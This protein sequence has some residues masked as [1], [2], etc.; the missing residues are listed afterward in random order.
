MVV[1]RS[2]RSA[3]P[4][5]LTPD[6]PRAARRAFFTQRETA[7][8][9]GIEW[10]LSLREWWLWWQ[11]RNRWEKRGRYGDD[12]VMARRRD[13]GP[14]SLENIY[15]T[16]AKQNVADMSPLREVITPR[17]VFPNVMEAANA[18]K[19]KLLTARDYA[20]SEKQGWRYVVRIRKGKG[21]T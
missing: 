15:C 10:D 1:I 5:S 9:R 16:T 12:L 11:I 19:I 6:I 14:Y 4:K 7:Y 18:Y 20:A 17:G 21:K 3:G 2:K 8:Q 13:T